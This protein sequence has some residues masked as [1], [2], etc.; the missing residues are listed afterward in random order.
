[1]IER[2]RKEAIE[3]ICSLQSNKQVGKNYLIDFSQEVLDTEM[4]LIY[5]NN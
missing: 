1:M 5:S 2:E 4:R 3:N